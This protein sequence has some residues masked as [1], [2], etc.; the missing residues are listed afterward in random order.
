MFGRAVAEV[1]VVTEAT[2]AAAAIEAEGRK[3]TEI[4]Y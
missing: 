4:F 3:P 1:R 2:V